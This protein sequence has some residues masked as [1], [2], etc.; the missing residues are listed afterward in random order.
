MCIFLDMTS[1]KI[2]CQVKTCFKSSSLILQIVVGVTLEFK[3]LRNSDVQG[4][5][6]VVRSSDDAC[7]DAAAHVLGCGVLWGLW[8]EPLVGHRCSRRS[9]L[10]SCWPGE[11]Y[12]NT[13]ILLLTSSILHVHVSLIWI[14]IERLCPHKFISGSGSCYKSTPMTLDFICVVHAGLYLL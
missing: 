14:D 5:V 7:A 9:P 6:S 8:E 11:L 1:S 2:F 4:F 3:S 12:M 13:H 10:V